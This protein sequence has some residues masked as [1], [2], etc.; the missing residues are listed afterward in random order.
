MNTIP[1][2]FNERQI[3][4]TVLGGTEPVKNVQIPI[5]VIILN[6][7]SSQFRVQILEMLVKCRFQS[8]VSMEKDP[9]N[10]NIEDFAR[11]F[12]SVRFVIPL[13]K[14]TDGDLINIGMS[15]IDSD[16]VLVIR[17]SFYLPSNFLTPTLSAKLVKENVYCIVP[18]ILTEK[19]QGF[20]IQFIPS[21]HKFMFSVSPSTLIADG[22]ATLY[23]FDFVGL[24]NR[25]KFIQLGGFDYSILAPYWQNM[26]L[27]FRSWLWGE[28]TIL[29]TAFQLAY[30][31]KT[32][33]EDTTSNLS[34]IRFFLKNLIPR[35][36]IDHG[37]MPVSSFFA[38]S[39]RS[40][41]GLFESIN[42][43]RDASHW[44]DK[45]KFRFCYDAQYLVDNWGKIE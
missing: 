4:R 18:R 42:Q 43:F 41:C 17:D 14:V 39:R 23:P 19:K 26:D 36:K 33:I 35:Y 45:N 11:R 32:P 1:L 5:S 9:S 16:F 25:K 3:N 20:P 37:F 38:F 27:A 15:E 28:K 24:Y 40:G 7:T 2:Y 30:R 12:P 10:Y 34:Y 22:M 21:V 31:T 44:I 8:I 6:S 29:S 13:E